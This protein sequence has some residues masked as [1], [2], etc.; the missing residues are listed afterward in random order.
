M[1]SITPLSNARVFSVHARPLGH[2]AWLRSGQSD[3]TSLFTFFA[4]LAKEAGRNDLHA[5]FTRRAQ[6]NAPTP[7]PTSHPA[8]TPHPESERHQQAGCRLIREGKAADALAEFREAIRLDPRHSD[9]HGNLGVALAHLRRLPE[10][11]AAFRLAIRFDATNTTMYVNLATCLLQQNRHTDCEEWA[12]Q[13]IQLKPDLAEAHRLLGTSLD[14]RRKYEAAE[15]AFRQAVTLE[16]NHAE[17]HFKLARVFARRDNPKEAE[18]QFREAVK[19]KPDFTSAWSSLGQLLCDLERHSEAVECARTAVTLDPKSADLHNALGVA[20]AGCEKFDEAETSYRQALRRNPKF[21][22]AHSNLGNCLRAAGKLDEAEKSLRESLKLKPDYAEAHNNLGIVLVQAGREADAQTHYDEAIRLRADY[23][24]ARMN[25][26]LS[27]LGNGDFVRGW[28]E[29]E[30]RFRVNAKRH[31]PPPGPKWAGEPLPGKILLITAEQ[32]LGDT[33]H[34]IRYAPLAKARVGT[35]LFDC[36]GPLASLVATCP[37]VDKV[38]PRGTGGVTYDAH[39]PLLSL[40]GIF[41]IPPEAATAPIPY[42]RPDPERV[43]FWKNELAGYSGLKVGIAWQGSKVH[44]GDRLRSVA[45]TRFAPLAAVPGVTLLSLQKPPGIE[46]LADGSAAGMGVI[47]L[48]SKIAA[49]MADA[50]ALMMSMDLVVAVD[51]AVVHLAGALGRPVWVALPFASDWRW[52]R[53]R[54]DSFWYPSMR[55]F[56]QAARGDWDGVFGR[57]AVALAAASRA[58]AEGRWESELLAVTE[59]SS[60]RVIHPHLVGVAGAG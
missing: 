50:A 13:A 12:R 3:D 38:A 55:L 46:Q 23:P 42:F 51:T 37:G 47:D 58:K 25:R 2:I 45:L 27:W 11:E 6:A 59:E 7:P 20:L 24:E 44:K 21:V 22:T 19:L 5:E 31:K 60:E 15:T 26:S 18:A 54:E 53:N 52:L 10:A 29:Y 40:P 33:I 41:G 43:A 30:W 1:T 48:G 8:H 57:L 4:N 49:E 9:A 34:F 56:R 16:P 28:P 14:A 36:P 17:A 35:V 39:I 32:G